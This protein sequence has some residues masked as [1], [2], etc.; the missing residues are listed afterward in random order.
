MRD[1]ELQRYSRHLLL[2][3]IDERG[4]ERL[5]GARALIIGA[6]GLG[7][8][9]AIYLAASGVGNIE[10]SDPD[11]VD[12]TNLQRQIAHRTADIGRNKAASARD[13]LTALNP[14]VCV[15]TVQ[16]LDGDQLQD[17]ICRADAVLDCSD[18]FDTRFALNAGCVGARTPLISGAA[19]GWEGQVTV[20]D[21]GTG[22]GCYRCLYPDMADT[23]HENCSNLGVFA[24][25]TG[26]V[27]CIQAAEALKLL[28]GL[29]GLQGRLIRMN[30]LTMEW[31][32]TRL[33]PDPHCPVCFGNC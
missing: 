10:I 1:A 26:I 19:I 7:S 13:T 22:A 11:H 24:P 20:I 32:E 3:Q 8:P 2:P 12:L 15:T 17:A 21:P 28:I 27:G 16:R 5:R 31:R 23:P 9:A 29:P 14:D 30:A 33:A 18:N 4:Q 25:L 6:G